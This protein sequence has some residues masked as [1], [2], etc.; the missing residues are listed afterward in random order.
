[1]AF[2]EEQEALVVKSWAV[3]K[4]NAGEL[5]MKMFLRIFEIAPVAKTLF[6]FLKDAEGP[7]EHN[8]KLKTHS[9]AVF[10]M[11]CE[12]A[13]Q[14]R[15]SGKPTARESSITKLAATH[16]K[17]GVVDAHFEVVKT[18]LLETIKDAVPE[19]WSPE[20]QGAWGEA[21]DE[22]ATAIK[23]EMKPST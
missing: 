11:A 20:M 19:M 21:Y 8:Q 13:V 9:V 7:L 4:P 22:L 6:S 15:K 5:G 14:L 18:A 12:S 3:M 17:S 16:I 1:M 23:K 2:S 10:V